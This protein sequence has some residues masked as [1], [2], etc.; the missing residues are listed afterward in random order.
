MN[1]TLVFFNGNERTSRLDKHATKFLI[2]IILVS[3][4]VMSCENDTKGNTKTSSDHIMEIQIGD[5]IWM[6]KNFDGATF[7]NGDPIPHIQSDEEWEKAGKEGKPAWCYYKNDSSIGS[8]YGR[9]YNWYAVNDPR[10]LSPK[11]WHTPTDNEWMVLENFLGF[12][13]AGL[14]LKCKVGGDKNE[15]DNNSSGFCALMGGYRGR[16][17]GFTGIEEFVYLSG[18]TEYKENVIWGRGLHFADSTMMRCGLDKEYG[19]YVR[20]IK[21]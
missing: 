10:G 3:F 11:G 4:H 1:Q 8:I 14:R 5:Q 9:M 2:L 19:L 20:C 16:E 6:A 7:R 21:D 12:S 18:S 17:G 13:N 15:N